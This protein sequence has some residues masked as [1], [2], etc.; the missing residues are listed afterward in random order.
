VAP[1]TGHAPRRGDRTIVLDVAEH[2]VR[3][4][5]DELLELTILALAKHLRGRL[6]G[7]PKRRVVIVDPH[8]RRLSVVDVPDDDASAA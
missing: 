6:R 2:L 1:G 7:G 4:H 5:L 3:E 8:G